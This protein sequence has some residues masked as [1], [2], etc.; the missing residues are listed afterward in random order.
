MTAR[1]VEV[2][3]A[4]TPFAILPGLVSVAWAE[5]LT[6]RPD[7]RAQG[8]AVFDELVAGGALEPAEQ[9]D[10]LFGLAWTGS[11]PLSRRSETGSRSWSESTG[12]TFSI[13]NRTDFAFSTLSRTL[14][15][16]S[17]PSKNR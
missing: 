16:D 8:I 5:Q 11:R 4:D 2:V 12:S 13:F 10:A 9:A 17:E 7:T 1:L 14:A 15:R 3:D 6:R